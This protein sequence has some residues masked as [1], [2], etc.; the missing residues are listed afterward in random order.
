MAVNLVLIV[1]ISSSKTTVIV[2][3]GVREGKFSFSN[4]PWNFIIS[5][6]FNY[7]NTVS[8]E[9]IESHLLGDVSP[10]VR[11]L[12]GKVEQIVGYGFLGRS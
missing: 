4:E 10:F 7:F 9:W 3:V 12:K 6:Y 1:V 2:V 5:Y 8:F 11:V